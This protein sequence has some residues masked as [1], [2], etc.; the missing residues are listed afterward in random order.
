M[1]LQGELQYFIGVQLDGTHYFE[2]ERQRLSEKIESQGA[3]VVKNTANN[4]DDALRELPDANM[5]PYSDL[6]L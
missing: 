3:K 1:E 2:P 6:Q 4:I 5:V